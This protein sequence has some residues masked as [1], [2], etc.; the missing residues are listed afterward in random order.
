MF[1][2]GIYEGQN[3]NNPQRLI[4]IFCTNTFTQDSNPEFQRALGLTMRA[5]CIGA[6]GIDFLSHIFNKP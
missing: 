3:Q 1:Y 4:T 5:L 2:L 6:S